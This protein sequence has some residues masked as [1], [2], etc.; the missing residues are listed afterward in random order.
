MTGKTTSG[1]E[2]EINEESLDDYELL[3][4]LCE[5]DD[6]NAAK[7]IQRI[8]SASRKRTEGSLKRTFKNRKRKSA[9][10]KN[11]DRNRRNL[12]QRKRRKNS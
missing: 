1:F 12:Q 9:G 2:Y 10:I 6:G 8:K 4:D 3:E 7:N 5:M 11:D